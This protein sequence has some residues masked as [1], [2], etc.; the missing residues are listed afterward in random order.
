M[1][2]SLAPHSVSY[3]ITLGQSAT[4]FVIGLVLQTFFFGVYSVLVLMSTRMLLQRGLKTKVNRTMFGI[5]TFM[6]LL[7][8]GY[9]VYSV[10]DV[11]ER[12]QNYTKLAANGTDSPSGPDAV[13]MWRPLAN[14]LIFINYVLN[15]GIV[16]WRA[17]VITMRSHRKYMCIPIVFLFFTAISVLL[18]IAFRI[19]NFDAARMSRLADAM[20]IAQL[21]AFS[22]SFISN[23]SSMGVVGA[24]LWKHWRT[25]RIAFPNK[26]QST[27]PNH[28]L[29]LVMESGMLYCVSDLTLLLFSVIPTPLP[30]GSTLGDLYAPINTQITGA[31]PSIVL[32][33]ISAHGSESLNDSTIRNNDSDCIS[34]QPMGSKKLAGG[35]VFGIGTESKDYP[36]QHSSSRENGRTPNR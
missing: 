19:A 33:L 13:L 32:L 25:I 35:A 3:L 11:V 31:Y 14:A 30:H 15:D 6:Y 22:T 10:L 7:S 8:A 27:R 17:W 4:Y 26:K 36:F 20:S 2:T 5:T 34:S 23:L 1:T 21:L 29:T 24:T 9:W 18:M 28:I 16:V 12:M